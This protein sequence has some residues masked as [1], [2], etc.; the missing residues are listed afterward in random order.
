MDF[1]EE[2]L[3]QI[4]QTI[5]IKTLEAVQELAPKPVVNKLEARRESLRK[6]MQ[7]KPVGKFG[8]SAERSE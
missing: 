8:Y 2:Q 6:L 3:A 4:N 1:T 5:A 7:K